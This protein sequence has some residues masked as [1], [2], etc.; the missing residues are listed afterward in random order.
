MMLRQEGALDRS[1]DRKVRILMRLRKES[2]NLPSAP[3]SQDDG[4]RMGNNEEATDSDM[5]SH[6]SQ[7]VEAVEDTKMTERHGNVYENKGSAFKT[8]HRSGNVK[9]NKGCYAF[10]TG[11]LLKRKV[12]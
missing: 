5:M 7:G 11:M 2:T 12:V 3:A 10:D 8:P 6:T 9:E 4:A 1:I